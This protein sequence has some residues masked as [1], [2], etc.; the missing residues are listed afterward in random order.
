MNSSATMKIRASDVSGQKCSEIKIMGE[1]LK[2]TVG[3]LIDDIVPRMNLPRNDS[4]GR[5]LNYQAL[6]E[7]EGRHL[8]STELI[9]EVLRPEDELV[10]NPEIQAGMQAGRLK[11]C[12]GAKIAPASAGQSCKYHEY[13]K[14]FQ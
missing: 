4:N 13:A 8:N 10:L 11:R 6:L 3:E 12:A 2:A 1:S 7:R 9:E 14:K 5:P